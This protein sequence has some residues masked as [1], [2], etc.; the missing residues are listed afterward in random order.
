MTA[1]S[2]SVTL[3]R[4][5]SINRGNKSV[6]DSHGCKDLGCQGNKGKLAL[7]WLQRHIQLTSRERSY[8]NR[9]HNEP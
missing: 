2:L 4:V 7:S 1:K 3:A 5:F 6:R 9:E 8:L